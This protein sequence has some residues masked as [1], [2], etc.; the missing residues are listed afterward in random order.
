[1]NL[2]RFGALKQWYFP[3]GHIPDEDTRKQTRQALSELGD[4]LKQLLGAQ[5]VD[6][7]YDAHDGKTFILQAEDQYSPGVHLEVGQAIADS[8]LIDTFQRYS[9][10]LSSG[11]L[12]Q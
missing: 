9:L 1:M 12:T 5:V 3:V 4:R 2:N 6:Y 7:G 11:Q 10:K 8:S